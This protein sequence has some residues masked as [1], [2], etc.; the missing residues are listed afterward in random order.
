MDFFKTTLS[1]KYIKY[2][3]S[4]THVTPRKSTAIEW[5]ILEVLSKSKG[6][7]FE[8]EGLYSIFSNYFQIKNVNKLISPSIKRLSDLEMLRGDFDDEMDLNNYAPKD[9]ELLPLGIEMHKKGFLKGESARDSFDVIYDVKSK[10]LIWENKNL[11]NEPKGIFSDFDEEEIIFPEKEIR[12]HLKSLKNGFDSENTEIE[13]EEKSK[14]KNKKQKNN[15]FDWLTNN[16]EIAFVQASKTNV[17]YENISDLDVLLKSEADK[18]FLRIK[19]NKDSEIE[20]LVL[21]S[22]NDDLPENFQ[23]VAF[24]N[25][26]NVEN[27][28]IQLFFPSEI[29]EK[30]EHYS[31]IYDFNIIDSRFFNKSNKNKTKKDKN[32]KKITIF[33]NSDLE[34]KVEVSKNNLTFYLSETELFENSIYISE[35]ILLNCGKTEIFAGDFSKNLNFAFVPKNKKFEYQELCKKLYEKYGEKIPELI[36]TLSKDDSVKNFEKLFANKSDDEKNVLLKK[37]NEANEKFSEN[38]FINVKKYFNK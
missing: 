24:T 13:N 6:T 19:G 36:L 29:S 12:S 10:K 26:S 28:A 33:F 35:S 32:N 18:N 37:I 38:K 4:V 34:E 30:I 8:N 15:N 16:S 11:T 2:N 14:K 5:L 7:E 21:E 23:D 31:N 3:V 22:I 25:I 27:S 9:I 20:K 1:H 17:A